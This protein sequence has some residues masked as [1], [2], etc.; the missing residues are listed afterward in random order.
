M[1]FQP[2]LSPFFS[3]FF[4]K[5][6]DSLHSYPAEGWFFVECLISFLD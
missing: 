3:E 4:N 5:G 1:F 2:I 6:V